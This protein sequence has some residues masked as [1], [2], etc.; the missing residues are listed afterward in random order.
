MV[1]ATREELMR[2]AEKAPEPGTLT[3]KQIITSGI[4]D[5]L[6]AVIARIQSA[7]Y[8]IVYNT[9]TKEPSLVN[10]NMLPTQL[11]KKHEDGSFA[12]TTMKQEGGPFRG[13]NKCLLHE[14]S[15]MREHYDALG[16]NRCKKSNLTSQFQVERHMAH[17]HPQEWATIQKEKTDSEKA[18]DRKFQRN[19][20]ESIKLKSAAE[21]NPLRCDQCEFEAKTPSGLYTHKAIKH[22]VD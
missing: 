21:A 8:V 20:M 19:L 4:D 22:K 18:D 2:L 6:P 1:T 16:F 11:N 3:L 12:F 14:D 15:P 5:T 17:R 9:Q 10:R 13:T 7:G